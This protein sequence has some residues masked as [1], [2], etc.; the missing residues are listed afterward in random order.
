MSYVESR[1][2]CFVMAL[3]T[4]PRSPRQM[5]ER[6]DSP[7]DL[8][9]KFWEKLV[10]MGLED[11]LVFRGVVGGFFPVAVSHKMPCDQIISGPIEFRKKEIL[12]RENRW[13]SPLNSQVWWRILVSGAMIDQYM[14]VATS[15]FRLVYIYTYDTRSSKKSLMWIFYCP[16]KRQNFTTW[17]QSIWVAW[18][19]PSTCRLTK[20]QKGV[21]RLLQFQNHFHK[22]LRA[23]LSRGVIIVLLAI[24]MKPCTSDDFFSVHVFR[25]LKVLVKSAPL[26]IKDFWDCWP[27]RSNWTSGDF[28]HLLTMRSLVICCGIGEASFKFSDAALYLQIPRCLDWDARF[29]QKSRGPNEFFSCYAEAPTHIW[30]GIETEQIFVPFEIE[31]FTHWIIIGLWL[32][33]FGGIIAGE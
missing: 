25:C 15:T 31:H 23:K 16:Q 20:A 13:W 19:F 4:A 8:P 24:I 12:H 14:G 3:F 2:V 5:S 21:G 11:R 27:G 28:T 33:D 1:W 32:L 7:T 26:Q 9:P 6:P 18:G 29:V 10:N 22:F 17:T 30:S